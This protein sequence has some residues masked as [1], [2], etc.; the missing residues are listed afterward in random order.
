[1]KRS[2][3]Y[4]IAIGPLIPLQQG[5]TVT[6]PGVYTG[7][8]C[9]GSADVPP[10]DP[11][12]VDIAVVERGVCFPPEKIANVEAAGGYDA[13]LVFNR[14]GSDACDV[15]DW[16]DPGT[17]GTL[18]TF[19]IVPRSQG[20]A[21]F[22][23]PYNDDDCLADTGTTPLPVA[24]GTKS[25]RLTLSSVFDGWGYAHLYRNEG[26]KLTELDTYAID[27]TH[28]PAYASGFGDLT[29][30]EVATSG[31]RPDLAYFSYYGGG[32]RVVKIK[33]NKLVETGRYIDERGNDFWG[34]QTFRHHGKEYVAASDCDFGLYLFQYTGR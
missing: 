25:D 14:T 13:I 17:A 29:V 10:G 5:R 18:P 7:M 26:G 24:I 4:I 1:M 33:N 11:T 6:G 15:Q 19:G 8:A 9:D 30:H 16:M 27:E 3:R 22:D 32:L 28:D 34:V 21:L 2:S 23:Q 31:V 20:F 12:A